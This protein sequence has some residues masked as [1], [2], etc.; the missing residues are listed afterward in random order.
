[1]ATMLGLS[2]S[3]G[4]VALPKVTLPTPPKARKTEDTALSLLGEQ[5]VKATKLIA[6]EQPDSTLPRAVVFR[7]SFST[8]MIP[9]LSEHFSRSVYYWDFRLN[10]ALIDWKRLNRLKCK[11]EYSSFFLLSLVC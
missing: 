2:E 9:Y 5:D 11:L 8:A 3:I 10:D 7:D 6:F 4:E 1:L